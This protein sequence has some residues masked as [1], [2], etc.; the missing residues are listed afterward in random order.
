MSV[1]KVIKSLLLSL[2]LVCSTHWLAYGRDDIH[3]RAGSQLPVYD[4]E[5]FAIHAPRK[6]EVK[7]YNAEADEATPTDIAQESEEDEVASAQNERTKYEAI[8][9]MMVGGGYVGYAMRALWYYKPTTFVRLMQLNSTA[10]LL[11]GTSMLWYGYKLYNN[12]SKD[13]KAYAKNFSSGP[14]S[15]R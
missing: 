2:F 9:M 14:V 4:N 7:V 1:H 5:Y 12:P 10:S 3:A 8:G 6:N 15:A 13:H 11:I